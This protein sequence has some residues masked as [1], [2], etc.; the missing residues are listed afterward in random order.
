M[1]LLTSFPCALPMS[2]SALCLAVPPGAAMDA[3]LQFAEKLWD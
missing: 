3:A 1:S 2:F